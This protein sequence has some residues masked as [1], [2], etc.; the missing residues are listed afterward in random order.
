MRTVRAP[1]GLEH[2][3]PC[4]PTPKRASPSKQRRDVARALARARYS[5]N[6][7]PLPS[8]REE[9]LKD[10]LVAILCDGD[11]GFS[12]YFRSWSTPVA[13]RQ[14][15]GRHRDVF[16]L[17]AAAVWDFTPEAVA[18]GAE[19]ALLLLNGC[20]AALNFLVA[21]FKPC[22][23]AEVAKHTKA[24]RAAVEH[25][26]ARV[27]RFLD[28]IQKCCPQ[29][30]QCHGAFNRYEELEADRYPSLNADVVDLPVEAG[31]CET[32]S[33]IPEDLKN[34]VT[35]PA[36]LFGGNA[37]S[38]VQNFPC[39]SP[40]GKQRKEYLKLVWRQLQ[41]GKT[42]LRRNVNAVGDVFSVRKSHGRQREVWNG[43][44]ISA[45]AEKPPAPQY[46]ANPS[47]F[48]DLAFLPGQQVF[49]SKRDVH[50]CFD[51]LQAPPAI[52]PWFGRPPVTL[53]ELAQA[54][55][56]TVEQLQGFVVDRV[57]S[58]VS[59]EDYVYPVS[60]VWPMGFSWSSC[61]AQAATVSCCMEAGV[62]E[63]C[64]LT[65][66]HPPPRGL[67]ACGVA[68]DDTF[69]FH[70]DRQL[71]LERL[72]K[73]D[74]IMDAKGMPKNKAKDV[75]L[76][77]CMTAL[78]C[79]LSAATA[80]AEPATE[81]LVPLFLAWLD[82]LQKGSA[83]PC[84]LNRALGVHQ[85][86]C[87]LQRPL[88][89]VFNTVYE[90]V[91]QEPATTCVKLPE[92]VC[93]EIAV[94]TFLM[95]LLGA[96]LSRP[97][98]PRLTASDAAP[99]YGFGLAYLDC[100]AACAAHVGSLAERRG[101]FVKFYLEPGEEAGKDRLGTPHRLP[102]RKRSFKVAV[103]AR[104]KWQAHSGA[105]EA[106]G[107]QLALKWLLRTPKR[108]HHR[109]VVL[110]DAKAILGAA[111]K[112]RTSAPGIRGVIRHIGGL[113]LATNCLLRLV[114]VPSEYNPADAPSRGRQLSAKRRVRKAWRKRT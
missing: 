40:S 104:A 89:S 21:D 95:P 53:G 31:T 90:F 75:T 24:Q 91:L 83:S 54:A 32:Q 48:V 15:R 56:V 30:P 94:A 70:M 69:F 57:D 11:T 113:L 62:T 38:P 2:V 76:Q 63:D 64:F 80:T 22:R 107:L 92:C 72:N 1:P 50:T 25:L 112:G 7:K 61:V 105:L 18:F 114:Y 42:R 99:E 46:L 93:S 37:T 29:G 19:T 82:V 88:F 84:G 109:L 100:D 108:F 44:I 8:S 97:F 66:E 101:D 20:I 28:E 81:K 34:V 87:L 41:C 102:F 51:V 35:S 68:T 16:P 13:P 111:S 23:F 4:L 49:M 45:L 65:M 67:E 77:P 39:R 3:W 86:F 74:S 27:A 58:I 10:N 96:D 17:A 79:H 85:W 14:T 98:L 5:R 47:C 110:V 36:K 106:H 26:A 78:G 59:A 71:G 9:S 33:H 55:D 12:D 43:S 6:A 52:Q 103:S 60:T 73:L